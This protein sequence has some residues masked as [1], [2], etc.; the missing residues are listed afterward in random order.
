MKFSHHSEK[1]KLNGLS[2]SSLFSLWL[3][4]FRTRLQHIAYSELVTSKHAP[5]IIKMWGH[6]KLTESLPTR[7]KNEVGPFSFSIAKM[8][9]INKEQYCWCFPTFSLLRSINI[10]R[11]SFPD[12]LWQ[13]ITWISWAIL[14]MTLLL[15]SCENQSSRKLSIPALT[16][17]ARLDMES[18]SSWRKILSPSSCMESLLCQSQVN[19][20]RKTRP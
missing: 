20:I 17:D 9:V 6:R 7:S 1:N 3:P 2:T 11:I 8:Q 4:S 10:L 12:I 14:K 18:L 19:I 16:Q 15:S 13:P 5:K